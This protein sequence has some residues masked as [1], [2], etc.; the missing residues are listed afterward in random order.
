[1]LSISRLWRRAP[2]WRLLL[3]LAVASTALAAMFPPDRPHWMVRRDPGRDAAPPAGRLVNPAPPRQE[4]AHFVPR[5]DSAPT[6]YASVEHPPL[7]TPRSGV[8][9]FDGRQL[10][11]PPGNWQVLELARA[12]VAQG[13]ANVQAEIF[14]RLSGRALTGVVVAL[15]PDPVSMG[16]PPS[17][18]MQVCLTDAVIARQVDPPN[19]A[20]PLANECWV[21]AGTGITTTKEASQPGVIGLPSLDRL[22]A[23]GIV[24]PDRMLALD[25]RRSDRHGW[26]SA[27]VL[28]P[29]RQ[30]SS[31]RHLQAWAKGFASLLHRGYDRDLA[32][33]TV[34]AVARDP[35]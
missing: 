10:P 31:A 5:P 27:T 17:T 4:S 11:L 22:R 18:F 15:S 33:G 30:A 12:P 20:D 16:L 28:L 25:Y 9:A 2:A 34:P 24:V 23:A 14:G 8:I 32:A 6:D 13:V 3:A 7:G 26:L 35:E 19:P 29:E 1:M 21:L